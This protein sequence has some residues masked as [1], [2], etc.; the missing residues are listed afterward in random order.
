M[1]FGKQFCKINK[2]Q[3]NMEKMALPRKLGGRKAVIVGKSGRTHGCKI[4][5]GDQRSLAQELST[6]KSIFFIGI[7]DIF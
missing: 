3:T 6:F 7:S 4:L 2:N 5:F 1:L